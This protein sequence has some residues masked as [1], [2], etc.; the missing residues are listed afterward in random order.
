[1]Q[2]PI[3]LQT[4]NPT[5][6]SASKAAGSAQ[7][8]PA[9]ATSRSQT[10]RITLEELTA[11]DPCAIGFSGANRHGYFLLKRITD[12]VITLFALVTLLPLI[13]ILALVIM[14]DSPGSPIYVQTR[15]GAR[16]RFFRGK[17]YW[18]RVEFKFFKLRS[19]R[20]D[21]DSDIHRQFVE[22]YI[23]GD[24]DRMAAIQPDK[25]AKDKF[26][27]SK[28][29]RVTRIGQFIRKTSLDEL[30]QLWNVLLGDMSLVGP[31]PAIP[32]EVEKYQPWH[33]QRFATMPGITGPW[34]VSGRSRVSFDEMVELDIEYAQT[35]SFWGDLKVLLWTLPV[36]FLGKGAG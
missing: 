1:M 11:I 12:V 35:Q 22:A 33:Q 13:A 15:V 5:T 2:Q 29:P 20:T 7:R 23:D 25:N 19:M 17:P 14:I 9:N 27:I 24:K 21:A 31:R 18:Q 28:D 6:Q 10:H 3:G 8:A 26:K 32:Y 36:A 34:Q 30:P 4:Y 16:R